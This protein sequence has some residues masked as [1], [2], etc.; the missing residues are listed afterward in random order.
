LKK[1]KVLINYYGFRWTFIE[2]NYYVNLSIRKMRKE[3]KKNEN[4]FRKRPESIIKRINES[5]YS[6]DVHVY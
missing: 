1:R 3:K 5:S 6:E 4:I 2:I